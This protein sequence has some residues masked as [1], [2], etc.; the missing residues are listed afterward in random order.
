MRAA[1]T[2]GGVW[3]GGRAVRLAL[4]PVNPVVGKPGLPRGGLRRGSSG[5]RVKWLQ[6]RLNTIA[7]PRGHGA[8]GGKPLAVDGV[9]GEKTEKVVK[10]FQAHRGLAADGVVGSRTWARL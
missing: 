7:G 2:D 5:E 8:L 1:Q 3:L 9:F 6:R 4:G 10:V